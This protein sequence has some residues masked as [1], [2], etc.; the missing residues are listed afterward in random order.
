MFMAR[1][2]KGFTFLVVLCVLF[3]LFVWGFWFWFC[4]VGLVPELRLILLLYL[5]PTHCPGRERPR[6]VDAIF[7]VPNSKTVVI[8]FECQPVV[9]L[10][11]FRHLAGLKLPSKLGSWGA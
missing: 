5:W 2:R 7:C 9:V 6:A 4:S 10:H 3:L 1:K 11:L 8:A